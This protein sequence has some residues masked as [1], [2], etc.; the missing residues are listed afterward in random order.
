MLPNNRIRSRWGEASRADV[1]VV[2]LLALALA[3]GVSMTSLAGPDSV[4]LSGRYEYR[5]DAESLNII[6]DAVCFFPD[7]AST[8]R[9]PRAAAAWPH[10]LVLLQ[11]YTSSASGSGNPGRTLALRIQGQR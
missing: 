2:V 7:T 4:E 9:V 6:G 5:T 11:R 8:E 3:T 10:P 1:V